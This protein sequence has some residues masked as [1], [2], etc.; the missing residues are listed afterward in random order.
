MLEE[1][2]AKLLLRTQFV[3]TQVEGSTIKAVIVENAS[4]RQAIDGKVFVDATGRGDVVA[5]SGSP[6]TSAR[7]ECN[8][9]KVGGSTPFLST[10]KAKI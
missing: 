6:Y 5:Q 4:G 3:D 10:L 1:T 8:C 7:N 9:S 2:G